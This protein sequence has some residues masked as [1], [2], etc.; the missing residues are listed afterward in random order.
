MLVLI[1]LAKLPAL[2]SKTWNNPILA[3]SLMIVRNDRE[4]VCYEVGLED[5]AI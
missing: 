4:A 1:E 3:G 2:N 5:D